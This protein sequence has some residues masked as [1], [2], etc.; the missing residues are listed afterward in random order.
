MDECCHHKPP[1]PLRS[2]LLLTTLGTAILL[3]ASYWIGPL[4]SFRQ[5]FFNYMKIIWWAVL[6]GFFLG[7]VIDHFIPKTYVTHLFATHPKRSILYALGLGF[8]MSAC[9][10][11][12][13]AIA[14]E[15][16]KK[17]A[18]GPAVI[19]FLLASPWANLPLTILFFGFFGIKALLIIGAALVIAL[20]TGFIFLK[21]QTKEWIE[22]NP[23]TLEVDPTFSLRVDISKRW[24]ERRWS[25]QIIW[26]DIKGILKGAWSLTQMVLY[27]I[28][29]GMVLASLAGAF[30][31]EH[32]FHNYMGPGPLGLL[33]TLG[34]A[35]VIEICSEGSAP[36]AFE[37]YRQTGLIGNAFVFLM[38]GVVTDYT[39][40]GLIWK[41][42]GRRTAL[43]MVALAVPQVLLIGW[44]FNFL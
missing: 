33:I 18:P 29:F 5:I 17:G 13:L 44:F 21:L 11:G 30:V 26:D 43:W 15:L 6:L 7:G 34:A 39:E 20:I 25:T 4:D 3:I 41:N 8:L 40:I 27:W 37:L 24:R 16:Y 31:P 38:A 9:S 2:P 12:I 35:T 1:F 23:N 32:F 19:S 42:I 22:T 14:I 28:L 36:I 10:H